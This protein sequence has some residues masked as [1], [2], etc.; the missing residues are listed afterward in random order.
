MEE[1]V[2]GYEVQSPTL[3]L[4]GFTLV[5]ERDQYSV[6]CAP[7][8]I[9]AYGLTDVEDLLQHHNTSALYRPYKV[10]H[11]IQVSMKW[12]RMFVIM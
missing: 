12:C 1:G 6:V 11:F 8:A 4:N 2:W 7:R 10:I 9:P 3:K 5:L